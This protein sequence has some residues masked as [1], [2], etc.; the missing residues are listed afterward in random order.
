MRCSWV[1]S[2]DGGVELS[3]DDGSEPEDIVDDTEDAEGKDT[4]EELLD[5]EEEEDVAL[6]QPHALDA[7]EMDSADDKEAASD[8]DMLILL[9]TAVDMPTIGLLPI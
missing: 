7:D 9:D 1:I 3:I 6:V 8:E 5:V 4:P 2:I